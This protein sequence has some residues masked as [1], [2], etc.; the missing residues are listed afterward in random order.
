MVI[1]IGEKE[2]HQ[3]STE[4]R[5]VFIEDN[6]DDNQRGKFIL[7]VN[8]QFKMTIKFYLNN[9]K[10]NVGITKLD[11][12]IKQ[13]RINGLLK[14]NQSI[15]L[16][17]NSTPNS[18]IV[19][20]SEEF[21]CIGS[22][23][24]EEWQLVTSNVDIKKEVNCKLDIDFVVDGKL[25]PTRV[26]PISFDIYKQD[27]TFKVKKTLRRIKKIHDKLPSWAKFITDTMIP[28]AIIFGLKEIP[29]VGPVIGV[30]TG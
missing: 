8:H 7:R 6:D 17:A 27:E 4:Y 10:S 21:I 23:T 30:F 16:N 15:V 14:S 1:E 25:L 3:K 19:H 18:S 22:F 5:L 29:F 28:N 11:K 26:F 12:K 9:D 24:S 20:P 13:V 2:I